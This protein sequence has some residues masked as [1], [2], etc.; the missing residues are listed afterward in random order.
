M[1]II[2]STAGDEIYPLK[3]NGENIKKVNKIFDNLLIELPAVP[4][5]EQKISLAKDGVVLEG[6]VDYVHL[7]FYAKGNGIFIHDEE[8]SLEYCVRLK[9]MIVV[10]AIDNSLFDD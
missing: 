10:D 7:N 6:T 3:Y 1:K 9:D 2:I 4:Y 5:P 8:D